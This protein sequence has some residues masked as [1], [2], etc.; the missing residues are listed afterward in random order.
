M[1][2]KRYTA[3]EIIHKLREADYA[4]VR[5]LRERNDR[6]ACRMFRVSLVYL[7][8]LFL[9]MIVELFVVG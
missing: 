4:A 2:K 7:F 5:V 9:A 8:S 6:A 1:P 3:E